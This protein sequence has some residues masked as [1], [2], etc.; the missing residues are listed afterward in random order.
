M[1]GGRRCWR[2]LGRRAAVGR[3]D[4]GAGRGGGAVAVIDLDEIARRL[5]S[6]KQIAESIAQR[7]TA[8]S[9][10]LSRTRQV[11]QRADCG[12]EARRCPPNGQQQADVTVASWEQQANAN[13]NQ[14]KQQAESTCNNHRVQLVQQFRDQIKPVARRVAQE[15]GLTVI[16]TKNDSVMLR[17]HIGPRTSRTR[18]W[19][20]SWHA[21]QARAAPPQTR[22]GG[23][24]DQ[25]LPVCDA[26]D[27][28]ESRCIAEVT[29]RRRPS[30]VREP[31]GRVAEALEV[32]ARPCGRPG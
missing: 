21:A 14:V 9:Q 31:A 6:D 3:R 19:T 16:V 32:A 5:G 7:Q 13:L 25:L 11:L 29:S 15:R 8:L 12:A 24:I 28:L 26:A 18:W 22:P 10:Q 2:R 4:S 30:D 17:L 27:G 1:D 20:S 23:D